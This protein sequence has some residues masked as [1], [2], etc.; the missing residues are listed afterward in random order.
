MKRLICWLLIL[1]LALPTGAETV[2][3]QALAFIQ[4]AGIRADSVMR[5]GNEI[6]VNLPGGGTAHLFSYGD[7]DQFDLSWRFSGATDE[8][9]TLYLDHALSL[10]HGLEQKIPADTADLS[11]AEAMRARNYT[12]IVSNSLL[13]MENMG[14]QGLDILLKQLSCHDDSSLNSL[15]ARLASRLLGRLDATPVDPAEGLAWYDALTLALQ[16]D[17]P[18]PEASAYV[19]DPFLAEVTQLMIAYEE[20]QRKDYAYTC[21]VDGDKA[22]T[23]VYLSAVTSRIDGDRAVVLCHMASEKIALYDGARM[24]VLSGSWVPCRIELVKQDGMWAITQVVQPGDGTEYWPS[25]VVFCDGVE[26]VAASLTGA[27]TPELHAEHEA[28]LRHW[29]TTIGY[30]DVE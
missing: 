11:A 9:L 6:I 14:Q 18:M 3:D 7:F 12:V 10:L 29:L 22:T 21:D 27:N 1:L 20:A 19:E 30:I 15:R 25:I 13:Y 24:E 4:A 23:F 28:A 16:D 8:E 5:I 26:A 17:L 2:Q